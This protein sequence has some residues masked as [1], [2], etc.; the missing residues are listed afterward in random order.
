MVIWHFNGTEN[1]AQTAKE[2]HNKLYVG[3]LFLLGF[4]NPPKTTP[5]RRA[6]SCATKM[7][8]LHQLPM[9]NFA[10]WFYYYRA[11]SLLSLF[12]AILALSRFPRSSLLFHALSLCISHSCL[13]QIEIIIEQKK[14]RINKKQINTLGAKMKEKK[15][16]R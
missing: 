7:R 16:S 15:E 14:K 3:R 2:I 10:A 1:C 4:L 12:L 9:W 6:V 5:I 8:W 11:L 13:N